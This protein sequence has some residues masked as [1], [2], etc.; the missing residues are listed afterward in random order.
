LVRFIGNANRHYGPYIPLAR[1][2]SKVSPIRYC[3]DADDHVIYI[4]LWLLYHDDAQK[5]VPERDAMIMTLEEFTPLRNPGIDLFRLS[6]S[7]KL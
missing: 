4:V 7:W 5:V 6:G 2:G 1:D 3:L